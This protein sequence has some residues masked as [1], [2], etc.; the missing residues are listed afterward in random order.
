MSGAD[1]LCACLLGCSLYPVLIEEGAPLTHYGIAVFLSCSPN[2]IP[3]G[4]AT[5]SPVSTI[6]CNESHLHLC[7]REG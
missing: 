7:E 5:R 1:V 4:P 6:G 2:P 3:C